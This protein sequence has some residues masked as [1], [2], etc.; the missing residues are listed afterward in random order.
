M[1]WSF[2]TSMLD[3]WNVFLQGLKSGVVVVDAANPDRATGRWFVQE[4]G[5][6]GEGAN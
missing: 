3:G 5:Q 2:F 1:R 4:I 6:R